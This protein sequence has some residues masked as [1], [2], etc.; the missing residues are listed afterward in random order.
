MIVQI[1]RNSIAARWYKVYTDRGGMKP[2]RENLCHFIRVM[3]FYAPLR[4]LFKCGP[5]KECSP[6]A[7]GLLTAAVIAGVGGIVYLTLIDWQSFLIGC[8]AGC[9]LLY[10]PF[11]VALYEDRMRLAYTEFRDLRRHAIAAKTGRMCPPVEFV[12]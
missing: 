9:D 12:E 5:G 2:E 4:W 3:L 1:K 7:L 10:I 11:A 8:I 6:F